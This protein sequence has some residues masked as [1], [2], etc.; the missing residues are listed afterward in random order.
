M[1]YVLHTPVCLEL[2]L[3]C[4]PSLVPKETGWLLP[5]SAAY[6]VVLCVV[7]CVVLLCVVLLCVTTSSLRRLVGYNLLVLCVVLLRSHSCVPVCLELCLGCK[8]SLL[9]S[10][11]SAAEGGLIR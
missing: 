10:A 6:S 5:S 2:C 1:W 11:S 4:E 9:S 3:G 7:L 8:P